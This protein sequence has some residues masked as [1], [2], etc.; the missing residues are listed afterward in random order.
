MKVVRKLNTFRIKKIYVLAWFLFFL[1][2]SDL[3]ANILQPSG[4]N[5]LIKLLVGKFNHTLGPKAITGT[6]SRI[7]KNIEEK[8]SQGVKKAYYI[9]KRR[10]SQYVYPALG[11]ATWIVGTNLPY[12]GPDALNIPAVA[13][14]TFSQVITNQLLTDEAK[15]MPTYELSI[16]GGGKIA[17][18][19][20]DG[21]LRIEESNNSE[22]KNFLRE[23]EPITYS[24]ANGTYYVHV[25]REALN[26]YSEEADW[27]G[28]SYQSLKKSVDESHIKDVSVI[29][30]ES[31]KLVERITVNNKGKLVKKAAWPILFEKIFPEYRATFDLKL[32]NDNIISVYFDKGTMGAKESIYSKNT[33]FIIGARVIDEDLV[34]SIDKVKLGIID[35]E[36]SDIIRVG[37]SDPFEKH[38]VI[39][40]FAEQISDIDKKM[41]S[42]KIIVGSSGKSPVVETFINTMGTTTFWRNLAPYTK[43]FNLQ[44]DGITSQST[45]FANAM[46]RLTRI[47]I[48][49][50]ISWPMFEIGRQLY[51]SPGVL[52]LSAYMAHPYGLFNSFIMGGITGAAVGNR[53]IDMGYLLNQKLSHYLSPKIA[54]MKSSQMAVQFPRGPAKES[55][56]SLFGKLVSYS[57]TKQ[58]L[59]L[60]QVR[61][62]LI[63]DWGWKYKTASTTLGIVVGGLGVW[64]FPQM[65]Q[66]TKV[67]IL[68]KFFNEG[69]TNFSSLKQKPDYLRDYKN[70]QEGEEDLLHD[71]FFLKNDN[72]TEVGKE[73]KLGQVFEN[74]FGPFLTGSVLEVD[75]FVNEFS[76]NPTK[77][78]IESV[79]KNSGEQ[80]FNIG[81]LVD[82]YKGHPEELKQLHFLL[83]TMVQP[84]N[85]LLENY[86]TRAGKATSIKDL[87]DTMNDFLRDAKMNTFKDTAFKVIFK[88]GDLDLYTA[89]NRALSFISLSNVTIYERLLHD[90]ESK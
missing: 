27:F 32:A 17:L 23:W 38:S 63:K 19:F 46:Q 51:T 29:E 64:S 30:N 67:F 36:V 79:L 55:C 14:Y 31:D 13:A 60:D 77:I 78:D 65:Y 39:K 25:K 47:M 41:L 33:D 34:I 69:K 87:E 35:P 66:K 52:N 42:E 45:S 83:Y 16:K 74:S 75:S 12:L 10:F 54:S 80:A 4:G 1:Q 53:L 73:K 86:K 49:A 7:E 61:N 43:F 62:L 68:D 88:D 40:K 81:K 3:K 84:I 44:L 58:G 72:L 76:A 59:T 56:V 5:D 20:K 28:V 2:V 6:L 85:D 8:G 21:F 57:G 24:K 82:E 48:T 90:L 89:A 11:H 22:I 15:Y 37:F 26:L 70:Y 18:Y 71:D 50:N 9:Y